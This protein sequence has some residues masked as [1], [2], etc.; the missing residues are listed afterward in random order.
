M[1][2][3]LKLIGEWQEQVPRLFFALNFVVLGHPPAEV[4]AF[5]NGQ[6]AEFKKITEAICVLCRDHGIDF[7]PLT[8]ILFASIDCRT[9]NYSGFT[10]EQGDKWCEV[11]KQLQIL[12]EAEGSTDGKEKSG[13]SD[14]DGKTP[15]APELPT[16]ELGVRYAVV[17]Y[18]GERIVNVDLEAAETFKELIDAYPERVGL[19]NKERKKPSRILAK[20]PEELR[21]LVDTNTK[22]SCIKL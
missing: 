5:K 7:A 13:V 4:V 15:P 22:G 10:E 21:P 1:A 17:I 18:R 14:P 3:A 16:V 9:G 12:I 11:V 20:L 19:T 2:D 6:L 8:K